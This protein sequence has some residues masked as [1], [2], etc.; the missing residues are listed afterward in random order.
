MTRKTTSHHRRSIR[1]K[2]YDYGAAGYYYITICTYD[3]QC[4][5]GEIENGKSL[6][7]QNGKIVRTE[8]AKTPVIRPNVSLDEFVIMPNHLHGIIIIDNNVGA[9]RNVPLHQSSTVG[10]FGKSI[11]NSIPTIVKLY[12][13][14]VTK[15]INLLRKTPAQPVWQRNYYEHII[16][17]DKELFN[18]RQYINNNPFQWELDNENPI[19]WENKQ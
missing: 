8:W 18:I 12:K 3:H 16:R 17:N 19:N 13:S 6:L 14:T 5:F 7:N 9:H 1:L 10:Q 4:L 2:E 11:S 15:Q